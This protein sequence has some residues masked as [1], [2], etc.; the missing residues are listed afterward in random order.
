MRM[1][2]VFMQKLID[3]LLGSVIALQFLTRLPLPAVVVN[4]YRLGKSTMWFPFAGMIIGL[5]LTVV[6]VCGHH[7]FPAAVLAVLLL[8]TEVMF[9]GGMHLDGY[10]DTIDGL[11]SGR[12]L[13][14]ILEI[15]RDS[16]VGA[17]GAIGLILLLLLK[18]ALYLSLPDKMLPEALF[19]MP[20]VSRWSMV[21]AIICFSYRRQAGLGKAFQEHAGK[22]ELLGASVFTIIC[23]YLSLSWFGL[24]SFVCV[25]GYTLLFCFWMTRKLGGMTGDTYGALAETAGVFFLLITYCG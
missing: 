2:S 18:Y 3:K 15:M 14:G 5:G 9:T 24:M 12:S 16:R 10:T 8:F 22:I 25:V 6:F 13:E 21:L 1:R 23:S 7:L 11:F 17:F 19:F 4:E 20:V